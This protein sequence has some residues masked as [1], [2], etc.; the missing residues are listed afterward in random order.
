MRAFDGQPRGSRRQK[1]SASQRT[2]PKSIPRTRISQAA[3]GHQTRPTDFFW[4]VGRYLADGWR[5][6]TQRQGQGGRVRQPRGGGRRGGTHSRRVFPC[7][8]SPERTVVKFHITRTWFHQW[9]DDFGSGAGGKRSRGGVR[10]HRPPDG[11]P[12]ALLDGYATGDGSPWQGGWKSTTISRALAL[13]ISL[14]VQCANGVVASIH[15][16]HV[17]A[18]TIIE[19]R[20]RGT[21][22]A[23][24]GGRA[25]AQ[26][27]RVP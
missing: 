9:L 5:T 1:A 14:L 10:R 7:T 4:L 8:R 15:E 23:V 6:V 12:P 25:A 22:D 20:Q 2:W 3:G 24:S 13:G 18:T 16:V 17:P 26:R 27:F 21:T 11:S 19:G